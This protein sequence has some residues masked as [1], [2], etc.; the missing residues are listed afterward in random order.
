MIGNAMPWGEQGYT[1]LEAGDLDRA[2][3]SLK[4]SHYLVC[5]PAGDALPESY[6]TLDAARAAIERF[7]GEEG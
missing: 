6:P 4:I 7:E 5:S 3:L 2:S 1:I